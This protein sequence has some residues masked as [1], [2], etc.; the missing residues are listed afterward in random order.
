MI[1]DEW[2]SNNSIL[3]DTVNHKYLCKFVNQFFITELQITK[4]PSPNN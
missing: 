4:T 1:R 2:L 3:S